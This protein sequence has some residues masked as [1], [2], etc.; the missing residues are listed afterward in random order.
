MKVADIAIPMFGSVV[1]W[2]YH[3]L[4]GIKP[5]QSDPGMKHFILSR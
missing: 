1:A 3:S 4:A 2:F 5:D